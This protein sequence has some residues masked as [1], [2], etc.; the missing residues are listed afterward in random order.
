MYSIG[1][2]RVILMSVSFSGG[3]ILKALVS[4]EPLPAR[5]PT[6]TCCE[7]VAHDFSLVGMA[8]TAIFFT[9]KRVGSSMPAKLRKWPS[10]AA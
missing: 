3:Q 8:R 6:A 5:R 4:A 2:L 7:S 10:S 9:T 1:R